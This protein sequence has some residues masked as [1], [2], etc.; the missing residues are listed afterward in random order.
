MWD[1]VGEEIL[2]DFPDSPKEVLVH[3]QL[4]EIVMVIV[5]P[6]GTMALF[7]QP[8]LYT[9]E[10]EQCSAIRAFMEQHNA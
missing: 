3:R 9:D 8:R 4:M 10:D 1:S 2:V 6:R 5:A 7:Q